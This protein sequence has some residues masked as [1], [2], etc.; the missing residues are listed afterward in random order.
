MNWNEKLV[1]V[2]VPSPYHNFQNGFGNPWNKCK[3]DR[4]L[5]PE[6]SLGRIKNKIEKLLIR[7]STFSIF[8]GHGIHLAT[9]S[10]SAQTGRISKTV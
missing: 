2:K 3:M 9:L 4:L 1:S 8:E 5:N 7:P 10:N 6:F